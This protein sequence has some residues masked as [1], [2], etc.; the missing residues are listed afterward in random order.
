M[1][2][3]SMPRKSLLKNELEQ[4]AIVLIDFSFSDLK[5][6]KYRPAL[7]ISNSSYNSRSLDLVVLRITS[8]PKIELAI[9]ITNKDVVRGFL[10]VESYVKVD[11]IFTIE[12]RMIAKVVAQ[13][14]TEK[15][16]AVKQKLMEL[17]DIEK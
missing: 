11:S 9:K 12:K 2:G 13:L 15:L 4:G 8:K 14:N 7:V 17:F 5:R 10:E 1:S 6:S 3:K 16:S